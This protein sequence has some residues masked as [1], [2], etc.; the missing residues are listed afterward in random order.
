LV[1]YDS[2]ADGHY[3]TEEDR[4]QAQ[5]PILWKS[6]K[7]VNVANGETCKAQFTT[8]LLFN[9]LSKSAR[10]A[11]TFKEFPHSLM[12][13]GKTADDGKISIFTKSGITVHKEQDVLIR[14]TGKPILI[15]VRDKQGRYRIPLIQQRGQWQ[16][17]RP[18]K[19]ARQALD[20]ANS[21]YD[22]PSTEQAVKWMHAVCGYPVKST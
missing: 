17:R 2:G 11:D 10:V 4:K 13:V 19:K 18:S 8:Q 3:I 7:R 9:A 5:L 1:I 14:M 6:I 20:Q 16:P 12:S 15:G 22:L 21:E